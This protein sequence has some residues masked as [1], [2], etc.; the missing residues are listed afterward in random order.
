GWRAL[1]AHRAGQWL[2]GAATAAGARFSRPRWQR[3]G[4]LRGSEP[5][6]SLCTIVSLACLLGLVPAYAADAPTAG[7]PRI[8]KAADLPRF[9]YDVPG[10][11]EGYVRSDERFAPLAGA[12]RRDTESV[13]ARFEIA[14]KATRR[15]LIGLLALLD[16][17]D[18]RYDAALA[19]AEEVR[20]LQEKPADRLLS[21]LQL[22]AMAN[23]AKQQ[24]S[25]S[26]A[27]KAAVGDA[28][29]R[30]LAPLPFDV[31]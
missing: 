2:S 25:G 22:R 3:Q 5:M 14:D 26:D 21:G 4:L 19:R 17:L 10:P 1:P 20:Q 28:I 24:P 18:G 15:D 13:L 29:A 30:E 12:L 8:E 6:K 7:K 27:W 16:Y 31:V 11:L 9:T 23:A